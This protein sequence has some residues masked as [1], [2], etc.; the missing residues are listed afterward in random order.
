LVNKKGCLHCHSVKGEGG[1]IG[2]DF[3]S[4]DFGCS[5]TEIAGRMWNHGPQMWGAMEKE[6]V[7]FP[8]FTMTE[9][10]NV[11]A[12]LFALD[13][14]DS[15]GDP[16]KGRRI[17]ENTCSRCH[18]DTK[19]GIAPE[20]ESLGGMQSPLEMVALMWNHAPEMRN[21]HIE[22]D[23]DWPRLNDRQMANLFAYLRTST[24]GE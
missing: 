8:S 10:A 11:L 24:P 17:V 15:P 12:Y 5:L 14:E 9:M 20:L 23:I 21:K 19:G 7:A 6:D 2:P 4:L 1:D 3:A 13:L 16:H 18:N 22:K